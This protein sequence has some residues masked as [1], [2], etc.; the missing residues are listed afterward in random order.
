MPIAG[1][2]ALISIQSAGLSADIDPFGA[3]LS[4]LRDAR[5]RDLLWNGDP[6][7]WAG[8]APILFPIVGMLNK[9]QYRLNGRTY[10]LPKH[11]FARHSLFE[12]AERSASSVTFHLRWS[13]ATLAVYPFRFELDVRFSLEETTLAVSAT[14]KN[15]D[16]DGE[17]PFSFGFHPAL[18][19]PLP[20]GQPRTD[21]V[22][23]FDQNEPAPMRRIDENGL[24]KPDAYPS[25]VVGRALRL[26]D[27]LFIEDAL[28]FD[29]I[30]S[31]RLR[32]G[33]KTGPFLDIGFPD[34]ERLG[35][36]TKPRADYICIEPWHGWADLEG[37]EGDLWAKSGILT[38][39]PHAARRM[40]MTIAVR[41]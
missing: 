38:V 19:W 29:Q 30:R 17:M 1:D 6:T 3:Q 14:V 35:V 27:E 20:Y 34:T 5:R 40:G 11:G 26:R 41:A 16:P 23:T 13:E 28:I 39:A 10:A 4:A 15:L 9:G 37:F 24:V 22:I 8:R 25:P 33:G 32:Y 36:W 21:H 7:V 12:V 2:Q 18:C 31:R